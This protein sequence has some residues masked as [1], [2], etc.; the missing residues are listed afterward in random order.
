MFSIADL[1]ERAKA[2]AIIDSDYRLAKVIGI[3]HAAIS[4]YRVGKTMPDER[5]LSQLCALSGDDVAVW[6]AQIQAVRA[7][8]PEGRSMWESIA[9]RLS[10]VATPAI[11]SVLIAIG[12]V[13]APADSARAG[14]VQGLKNQPVKLL[15]IV[16]SAF[17]SVRHYA[18]VRLRRYRRFSRP[19]FGLFI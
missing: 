1:L 14:E 11:L 3:T 19:R 16:C 5:V 13:A 10:G 8:T 12:L 17:L 15:Y 2:G 9:A 4:N 7:R 18:R 6:A